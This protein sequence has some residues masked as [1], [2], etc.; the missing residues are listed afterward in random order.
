MNKRVIVPLWSVLKDHPFSTGFNN[1]HIND[2]ALQLAKKYDSQAAANISL[3][4]QDE[5]KE[6]KISAYFAA[7]IV[8]DHLCKK[9]RKEIS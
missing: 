4:I 1:Q 7:S 8:E 2:L 3:Q 5:M 9:A 6:H